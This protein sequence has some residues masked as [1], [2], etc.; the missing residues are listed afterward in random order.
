MLRIT[1]YNDGVVNFFC[2]GCNIEGKYKIN[3][4]ISDNCALDIN[5]RCPTCESTK[6]LYFLRCT[7]QVLAKDLNATLEVIKIRRGGELGNGNKING[8]VSDRGVQT[9]CC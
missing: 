7:N 9:E 3:N 2:G 5:V 4:V 6:T 8:K 1:D